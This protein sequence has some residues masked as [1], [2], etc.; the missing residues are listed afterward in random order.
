MR[1][2]DGRLLAEL[3]DLHDQSPTRE[4]L[5][6]RYRFEGTLTGGVPETYDVYLKRHVSAPADFPLPDDS[7]HPAFWGHTVPGASWNVVAD[8][9]PTDENAPLAPAVAVKNIGRGR[10]VFSTVAWGR[11][12][13]ERRDPLLGIWMRQVIEW[14]G[15]SPVPIQVEAPRCLHVGVT[16]VGSGWLLY[17]INQS[18]DIQSLRQEWREMM[19]VAD[20]PLPIGPIKVT[21][22]GAATVEAVYGPQP[23]AMTANGAVTACYGDFKDHVVLHV[24]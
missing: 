18:N 8:L 15:Q 11:Q 14:L 22:P 10:V 20:R 1:R 6:R 3:F 12:Y 24:R 16:R 19:K 2:R 21:A 4:Q 9:L 7:V 13:N 5:V 17:L 23:S